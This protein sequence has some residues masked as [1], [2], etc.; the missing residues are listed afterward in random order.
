MN[1]KM[2]FWIGWC[3]G[4]LA[5]TH[6]LAGAPARVHPRAPLAVSIHAH[7][8]LRA[9]LHFHPHCHA[10]HALHIHLHPG[11]LRYNLQRI[12]ANH[13]W[14]QVVWMPPED[15]RWVGETQIAAPNLRE[16]LAIVLKAYPLQAIFYSGNHILAIQARTI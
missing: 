8:R 1:K 16:A 12:A 11:S 5:M 3:C 2:K 9:P 7:P 14:P 6:A 10:S 15:Y 4:C 13:G